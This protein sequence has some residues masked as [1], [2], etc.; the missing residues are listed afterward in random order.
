[1][2]VSRGVWRTELRLESTVQRHNPVL[3]GRPTHF[4]QYQYLLSQICHPYSAPLRVHS[5]LWGLR[6]VDGTGT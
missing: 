5:L 4:H 6:Q 2:I 3:I 1:M